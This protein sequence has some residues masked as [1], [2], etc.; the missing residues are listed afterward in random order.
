MS[1]NTATWSYIQELVTDKRKCDECNCDLV[2]SKDDPAEITVYTR[3]GTKFAQHFHREC[4]NRWCRKSF[5]Y[6][7][8]VKKE[9]KVYDDLNSE[10]KYIKFCAIELMFG[11]E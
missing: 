6:G 2:D 1:G 7:Y 4:P 3:A 8:T 9:K 11:L 10:T 5:Y